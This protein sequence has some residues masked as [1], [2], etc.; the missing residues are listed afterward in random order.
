MLNFALGFLARSAV[1]IPAILIVSAGLWTTMKKLAIMHLEEPFNPSDMRT[2]PLSC[3]LADGVLFGLVFAAMAAALGNNESSI[4]IA[5][6]A[7]SLIALGVVPALF[8]GSRK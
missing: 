1:M 2:W 3:A 7:A 4:A 8:V 5:A 6:G